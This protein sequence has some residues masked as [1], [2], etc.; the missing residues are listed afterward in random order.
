MRNIINGIVYEDDIYNTVWPEFEFNTWLQIDENLDENLCRTARLIS[1]DENPNK[2]VVWTNNYSD[3]SVLGKITWREPDNIF[4][5]IVEI[6]INLDYQQLG[7]GY[8]LGVGVA[9]IVAEMGVTLSPPR[10]GWPWR[11]PFGESMIT[12][13]ATDYEID[14]VEFLWTDGNYYKLQ[15]LVDLGWFERKY[16]N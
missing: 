2:S 7:I 16:S 10:A 3:E 4:Y 15:D 8:F 12:K 1:S 13:W 6:V 5:Y 14:W 9:S 11:A